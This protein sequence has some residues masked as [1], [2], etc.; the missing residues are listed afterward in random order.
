MFQQSD[1][2]KEID[3]LKRFAFRLTYNA[4]EA[5]DLVQST[6]LRAL[7]KKHLFQDGTD[8]FKWTSKIMFNLFVSQYRRKTRFET[9]YDPENFIEKESVQPTQESKMELSRVRNAMQYLSED[10]KDIL[11]MVC[12]QGM[13]YE[14]VATALNVPVGTVR[15]RL[16]RAR[17][18]LQAMLETP[19][20]RT[21]KFAPPYPQPSMKGLNGAIVAA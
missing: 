9:K 17:E 20:A 8:L 21:N 6:L 4:D 13:Q 12:I 2:I 10:H 14:E 7:E 18:Q 11:V 5:E 1:L 16:S 19:M 15:S 3:G